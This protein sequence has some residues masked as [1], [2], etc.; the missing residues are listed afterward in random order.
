M[1]STLL[2][3]NEIIQQKKFSMKGLNKQIYVAK[4]ILMTLFK[5]M[6]FMKN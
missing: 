6:F 2:L 3:L 1:I 5:K 4:L